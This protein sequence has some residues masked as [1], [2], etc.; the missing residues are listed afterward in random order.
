ME[1]LPVFLFDQAA[2]VCDEFKALAQEVIAHA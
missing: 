1:N 2:P